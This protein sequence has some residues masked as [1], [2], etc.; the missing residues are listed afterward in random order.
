M[1]SRNTLRLGAG[2]TIALVVVGGL[3]W[4][5]TRPAQQTPADQVEQALKLLDQGKF[6]AAREIAKRLDEQGY[7]YPGFAGVLEFIQGMAA[8]GMIEASGETADRTQYALAIPFLQEAERRA[9]GN[10]RRPE[11]A[12]G[13]GKSLY[14]VQNGAASRPLLEESLKTYPPGR[15][16]AAEMLVDLYLDPG[17]RTPQLLDVALEL[18]DSLVQNEEIPQTKPDRVKRQ[19]AWLQR[20]EIFLAREQFDEAHSALDELSRLSTAWDEPAA[21]GKISALD[22]VSKSQIYLTLQARILLAQARYAE[23]IALLQPIVKS[24]RIGQDRSAEAH[25]LIG[26]ANER[27]S[28]TEAEPREV[29]DKAR[30]DAISYFEKTAGRY[31][32]TSEATAANLHVGRLWRLY[33]SQEK[34]L[35]AYGAA[36]RSVQNPQTFRN[37]WVGLDQFRQSVLEAWNAWLDERLFFEAI[38]LSELMTPLFPREEAYEFAARAH[39]RWAEEIE[40]AQKRLSYSERQK[41]S[42]ELRRRWRHSAEAFV[43]LAQAR[44]S[45]SKYPE[46]LWNAAEQYRRGQDFEKSLDLVNQFLATEPDRL[47]AAALVLRSR[48]E[49]DLDRIPEALADLQQVVQ[50]HPT[51]PAIFTAMYLIGV[52]HFELDELDKAEAIWRGILFSDQLLPSAVEWRD[53]QLSLGRLMFEKGE[54]ERRKILVRSSPPEPSVTAAVFRQASSHWQEASKLL[55]RY[56]DRN[57]VGPGVREARYYLGK[58]LQRE[59]EWLGRQWEA[60]ETDNARQQLLQQ[61]DAMLEKSLKQFESMRNDLLAGQ[62]QDQIDELEQR[63]LRNCFFE[64][65]HSLFQL[66]RYPEAIAAYNTAVSRYP[67]DVQTLVAFLQMDQCYQRMGKPVEARSML[68]QAKVIL[69]HK[70]I[71]DAAFQSPSTNFSRAEWQAWLERARL[72][73]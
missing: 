53:A 17:L 2:L 69:S 19:I 27:L 6:R 28:E 38:A 40:E 10:E 12:Y 63:L 70:Q 50:K 23:A 33:P 59:A 60:A 20:A 36:L 71:P 65:P 61:Q 9:L 29:R 42:E 52:C 45:S 56:L 16:D 24:N 34:S 31:A 37:R 46:A 22:D 47:M 41:Q 43:R 21:S 13:L 8:F 14:M 72:V 25:Y 54:L 35:L 3:S 55:G 44:I 64:I 66:R 49:L 57:S 1:L 58:S 48:I 26:L 30:H 73:Q 62:S 7:R 67:H 32:G 18:N 15:V 68:Q 51:D 39:V 4:W 5:M 11:W